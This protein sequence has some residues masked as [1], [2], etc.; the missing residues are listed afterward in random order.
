MLLGIAF[1]LAQAFTWSITSIILRNL[2]THLDPFLVNGVRAA[3]GL[4]IIIPLI[5][6]TGGQSDYAT[7]TATRVLLLGGSIAVGGVLGDAFFINSLRILGVG[8]AFPI[9]NTYPLFT[10]LFSVVLLDERVTWGTIAGMVLVMLGIYMVARPKGRVQE[11]ES[12]LPTAQLIKGVLAALATAMLWGLASVVLAIGL[13]G[14]NPIVANSVRVPFVVALCLLAAIQ[15]RQLGELR[16]L[17]RRTMG[18]LALAGI[19]GWGVGSS[20]FISAVQ[21]AG[22]SKTAIVS[23]A[24]PLFAIPLS[25]IFMHE[26]PNRYTLAGTILSVAGIAL[27]VV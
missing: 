8:R 17:D 16:R 19:L 27:V 26:R 21:L 10:V 2:S 24:A 4:L 23:A 7:L 11:T 22:P 25:T 9:T 6:L 13:H 1:A 5:F 20:L 12:S 3:I 18:L 15:R 14:M